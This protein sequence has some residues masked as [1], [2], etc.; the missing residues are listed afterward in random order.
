[1]AESD[2]V[3]SPVDLVDKADLVYNFGSPWYKSPNLDKICQNACRSAAGT[4]KAELLGILERMSPK[5]KEKLSADF[6]DPLQYHFRKIAIKEFRILQEKETNVPE[7]L[8]ADSQRAARSVRLRPMIK[9]TVFVAHLEAEAGDDIDASLSD[10][11]DV[12]LSGPDK[13]ME[14]AGGWGDDVGRLWT[15]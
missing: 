2:V 13:E 14:L 4:P 5:L 3:E 1:M 6:I 15:N 9:N 7:T 11:L 8:P 12:I 10:V